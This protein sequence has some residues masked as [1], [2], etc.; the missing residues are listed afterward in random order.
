M[1]LLVNGAGHVFAMCQFGGCDYIF[2]RA[3][4]ASFWATVLQLQDIL[5]PNQVFSSRH[6]SST[7]WWSSVDIRRSTASKN[8]QKYTNNG[9]KMLS[10][11]Q[12][13]FFL[14][15]EARVKETELTRQIMKERTDICQQFHSACFKLNNVSRIWRTRIERVSSMHNY[16]CCI[17]MSSSTFG[18]GKRFPCRSNEDPGVL[19]PKE[20]INEKTRAAPRK[21][22]FSS[23]IF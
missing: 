3:P 23:I 8:Y 6:S 16:D 7:I 22:K 21:Q 13:Y 5:S 17:K 15:K 10:L 11:P 12:F 2:A 9:H 1:T 18:W 20:L 19:Q 14:D 4:W